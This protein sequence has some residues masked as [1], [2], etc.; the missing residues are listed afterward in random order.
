[1]KKTRQRRRSKLPQ[2]YDATLKSFFQRQIPELLPVLLPGAT[3]LET[4]DVERIKPT[5]RA[6]RVYKMQYYEPAPLSTEEM[7][8]EVEMNIGRR[9]IKRGQQ[10]CRAHGEE[11]NSSTYFYHLCFV[12]GTINE[13]L[14]YA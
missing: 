2:Q 5:M 6:D 8:D 4:L 12:V 11:W 1:M 13:G 7:I 14:T 10:R 3:Y 9:A